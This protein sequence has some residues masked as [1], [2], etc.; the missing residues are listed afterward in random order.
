M[1]VNYFVGSLS[2][3]P[4]VQPTSLHVCPN[5]TVNYTCNDSNVTEI[6]WFTEAYD[7]PIVTFSPVLIYNNRSLYFKKGV[8]CRFFGR[9][10][11]FDSNKENRDLANNIVSTLRVNITGFDNRTNFTCKTFYGSVEFHSSSIIYLAGKTHPLY[12]KLYHPTALLPHWRAPS[13]TCRENETYFTAVLELGDMFDG[14]GVP[15]DHYIIELD[16]G[17]QLETPDPT[18]SF[19]IM[20]NTTLSVNISAHN[21]AGYSDP[22]PLDIEYYRE[23]LLLI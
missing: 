9:V 7:V 19:D 11:S 20:Y 4:I 21:C 13:I 2:D 16:N 5:D 18:D 23:G 17:T 6:N 12:V 14:G 1:H 15:I 22:I 8:D 10:T 3:Q